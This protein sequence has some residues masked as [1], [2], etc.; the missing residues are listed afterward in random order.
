MGNNLQLLLK[1]IWT[2][3]ST[4]IAIELDRHN[5]IETPKDGEKIFKEKFI[6]IYDTI[7]K[8][9]M[10]DQKGA[11]DRHKVSA[12][13][14]I[15]IIKADLLREAEVSGEGIYFAKYN[16]ATDCGLDYLLYEINRILEQNGKE[17]I[18]SFSFP[19]ATSCST[20]YYNIFSRNLY[21]ADK[22]FVLNPLDLA[23]RLFLLEQ[24]T[25]MKFNIDP[26]LFK[27]Y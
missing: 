10:E 22:G 13:I 3:I 26:S 12:I 14:M 8:S 17:L 1:S 5:N 7:L 24:L 2:N 19:E 21:Y 23:E 20:P 6:E 25:F 15:A 11:L 16:L 27:E 18:N 9:Y 4:G